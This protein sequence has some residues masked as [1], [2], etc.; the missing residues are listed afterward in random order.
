MNPTE[1]L[2]QQILWA[3]R[4]MAYNLDFIPDDKLEWK[5]EP[6]ANSALEVVQ[7]SVGAVL[8]L[9]AAVAG[10]KPNDVFA[11][12]TTRDEAKKQLNEATESYAAT[13]RGISADD[14]GREVELPFGTFSLGQAITL[15][16]IDLI[17]HHG[18]IA[19]IQTLL[20][21]TESHLLP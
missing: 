13:L 12:A 1:V 17:H 2:A 6:T 7:H 3:G 10:A 11:P 21:D 4:N 18:Q 9:E 5:P 16:V 8:M 20:G 14:F 15:A 19:Y